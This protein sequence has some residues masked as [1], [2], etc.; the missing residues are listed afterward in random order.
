MWPFLLFF[1]IFFR[2]LSEPTDGK[3]AD[4][5][6]RLTVTNANYSLLMKRI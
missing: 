2:V 6:S 4:F 3:H 1:V 5:F